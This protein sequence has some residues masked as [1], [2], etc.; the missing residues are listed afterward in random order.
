MQRST[1]ADGH[2][3]HLV[4]GKLEIYWSQSFTR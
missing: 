2:R 3:V 1:T 4:G